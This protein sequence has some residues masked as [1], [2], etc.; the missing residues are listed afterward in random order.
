MREGKKVR[1]K[2]KGKREGKKGR[3]KGKGKGKR[4]KGREKGKGKREGKKGREKGEGKREGKREEKKG[5]EKVKEKREPISY[6]TTCPFLGPKVRSSYV[7]QS[8]IEI[9]GVRGDL[10]LKSEMTVCTPSQVVQ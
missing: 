1:E 7:Y 8:K 10:Q 6:S 3:E 5:R 4:K 2:G 9:R